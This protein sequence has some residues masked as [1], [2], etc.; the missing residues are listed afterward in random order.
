M[1]VLFRKKILMKNIS[2]KL[3]FF[4]ILYKLLVFILCSNIYGES[5][6]GFIFINEKKYDF[7]MISFMY[8]YLNFIGYVMI[9]ICVYVSNRCFNVY[10]LC[11]L[12]IKFRI[13]VS[14]YW[15]FYCI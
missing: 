9:F 6:K 10:R 14:V 8:M 3:D 7:V 12:V 2:F 1:C 5:I 11:F 13:I 15:V 4:C